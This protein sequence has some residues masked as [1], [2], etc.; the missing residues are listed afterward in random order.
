MTAACPIAERYKV[1]RQIADRAGQMAADYFARFERLNVE[2]KGP[3]DLVSE[4]DREVEL[5]VRRQLA[6]HFPQD[7]VI[8]EEFSES[9]PG[10]CEFLWV[11]DPIDGTSNFVR[12]IP[13]WCVAIACVHRRSTV[14]GIVHDPLHGQMYHARNDGGAFIN[15][16]AIAASPA[17]ALNLGLVG[18][19]SALGPYENRLPAFLDG[20]MKRGGRFV[21][22]GSGAL[23]IAYVADGR[24]IAY[25]ERYMHA[26]DCLASMLLVKE[27]GGRVIDH[28]LDSMLAHGGSVL[29]TAPG[30]EQAIRELIEEAFGSA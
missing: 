18:V 11:I 10:D 22:G 12:G 14:I 13:V 16:R 28:N 2:S 4:A 5:Y 26:W 21:L 25:S 29:V 15:D 20:V 27:A 6:K 19:G 8:G 24:Y 23:G 9:R 17:D 1:A 30:V 7:G 3:G